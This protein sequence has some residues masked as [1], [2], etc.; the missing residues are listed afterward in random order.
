MPKKLLIQETCV[1]QGGHVVERGQSYVSNSD[2]ETFALIAA[3]R[4]VEANDP[5]VPR[6]EKEVAAEKVIKTEARAAAL[7]A[8]PTVVKA[9][10]PAPV[11]TPKATS[12]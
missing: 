3:G 5:E 10:S 2:E 11:L 9:G 6:I 8:K 4:A 7:A 12:A 1:V